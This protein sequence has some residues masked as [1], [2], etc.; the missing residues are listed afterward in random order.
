MFAPWILMLSILS[1]LPAGTVKRFN[2][3]VSP[4]WLLQLNKLSA[5]TVTTLL[6]CKL[7]CACI[8]KQL[9]AKADKKSIFFIAIK[10]K[11]YCAAMIRILFALFFH[12]LKC[13]INCFSPPVFV[14][15]ECVEEI[16]SGAG[17]P[18]CCHSPLVYKN[19]Y[20]NCIAWLSSN[21]AQARGLRQWETLII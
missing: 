6:N 12:C 14:A 21:K 13:Y 9:K 8:K 4:H 5:S 18:A 16:P 20:A 7:F 2:K 10:L 11:S 1:T 17:L 15:Q 19:V 3:N